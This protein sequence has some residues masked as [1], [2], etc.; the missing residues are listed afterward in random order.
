METKTPEFAG[1]RRASRRRAHAAIAI[2]A[3]A[4]PLA[5]K[6]ADGAG[7]AG[8]PVT[9]KGKSAPLHLFSVTG[10]KAEPSR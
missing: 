5:A 8:G 10:L 4:I 9:V 6:V 2:L 3:L 1:T 7:T